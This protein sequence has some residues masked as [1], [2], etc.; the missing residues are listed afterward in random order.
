MG[1][2]SRVT[3]LPGWSEVAPFIRTDKPTAARSLALFAPQPLLSGLAAFPGT[4]SL[5][6]VGNIGVFFV[7]RKP[8]RRALAGTCCRRTR[9]G[10]K[11]F[12]R[13]RLTPG[14]RVEGCR[15][16]S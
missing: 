14:P 12:K 15:H 8:V 5:T 9:G 1:V 4:E 16:G 3:D 10:Y 2:P 6:A 11:V 13:L 7:F